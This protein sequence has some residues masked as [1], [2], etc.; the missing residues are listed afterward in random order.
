[1]IHDD[2]LYDPIQGQGHGY[3]KVVKMADFK[4]NLLCQHACN[5]NTNGEILYPR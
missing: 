4:V 2:M 1:M 3:P 5:Q